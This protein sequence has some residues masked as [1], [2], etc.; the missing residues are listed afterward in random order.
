LESTLSAEQSRPFKATAFPYCTVLVTD[1]LNLKMAGIL[2]ELH[3]KDGRSDNLV[4][5]LDV[6]ILQIFVCESENT[7]NV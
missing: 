5:N 1:N 4:L 3:D 7:A 6:G 2:A